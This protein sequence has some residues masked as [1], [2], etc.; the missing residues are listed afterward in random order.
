[1]HKLFFSIIGSLALV[2][3]SCGNPETN[4]EDSTSPT[5]QQKPVF[6]NVSVLDLNNAIESQEEVIVLDVRTAD[7]VSQGYVNSAINVDVNGGQFSQGVQGMEMSKTVYVYCRSGQRSQKASQQL[8]DL[9][10]TDV[11]NVQGGYMAWEQAGY[12]VAK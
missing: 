3:I 10:F 12:A 7:E 4:S 1:M 6:K 9:G 2:A 8:L 5:E 11:R